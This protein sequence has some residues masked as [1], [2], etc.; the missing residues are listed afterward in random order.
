MEL[1]GAE[2]VLEGLTGGAALHEG[3]EGFELAVAEGAVEFQVEIDAFFPEDVG[4]E[5]LSIE[6][7]A[8][9][10]MFGEVACGGRDDLLDGFQGIGEELMMA[11]RPWRM[12]INNWRGPFPKSSMLES[13]SA[14]PSLLSATD[15]VPD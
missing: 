15:G 4:E 12:K 14:I 8:F 7:R 3:A 6:A 11:I 13:Q 10:F 5:Q 2:E 1:D 9:D